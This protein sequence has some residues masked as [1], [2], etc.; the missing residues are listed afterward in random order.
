MSRARTSK[1]PVRRLTA[2]FEPLVLEAGENEFAPGLGVYTFFFDIPRFEV[3]YFRLVIESWEDGAVARTIHRYSRSDR[4]RTLVVALVVPDFLDPCVRRL[5]RLCAEIDGTQ[6]RSTPELHEA[7][8]RD[9]S[10]EAGAESG[11]D[12]DGLAG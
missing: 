12:D 4:T 6:V 2:H 9:L 7:L 8:R 5:G 10:G 1:P 3:V 11:S